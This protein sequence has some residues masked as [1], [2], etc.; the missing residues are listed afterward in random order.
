MSR[1]GAFQNLFHTS[2]SYLVT[3]EEKKKFFQLEKNKNCAWLKICLNLSEF[4]YL[5]IIAITIHFFFKTIVQN[6]FEL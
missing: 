2:I 1:S 4:P 3:F 6:R 5:G